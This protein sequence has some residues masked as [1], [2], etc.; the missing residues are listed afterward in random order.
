MLSVLFLLQIAG[1]GAAPAQSYEGTGRPAV[2]I[3]RLTAG[4]GNVT[5]DGSLTEPVWSQAARLTGFRQYQPVDGRPAEARTEARVFYSQDAIYFGVTAYA[6]DP[7]SIR[8]TIADRD[9]SAT[10]T[11]SRSTSTRST[12]SAGRTSSSSTR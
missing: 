3:P 2:F 5:I 7:A 8:A 1:Q 6:K 12:T 9:N 11:A 10:K 4:A